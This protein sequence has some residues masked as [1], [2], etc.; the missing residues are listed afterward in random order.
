MEW[1][2]STFHKCFDNHS[3]VIPQP[4]VRLRD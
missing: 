4:S 3:Q 2:S 1:I